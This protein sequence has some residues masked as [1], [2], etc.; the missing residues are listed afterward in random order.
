MT[1][2]RSPIHRALLFTTLIAGL[3]FALT[4]VIQR[5]QAETPKET[6]RA[7][8]LAV[9]KDLAK[10]TNVSVQGAKEKP[11]FIASPVFRYDDQP[12]RFIDATLW[13]WTVGG[14]PIAFEKI[15]A[16]FLDETDMPR[17]GFC[18]ASV[19][20]DLITAQWPGV[21]QFDS[22]EPAVKFQ[23]IP[24]APPVSDRET[25][26]KRQARELMRTF[27]LRIQSRPDSLETDEMRLLT[28]PIYEYSEPKSGKFLGAVYAFSTNGTNPDV[29]ILLEPK[30]RDDKL[31]WQFAPVRMTSGALTMKYKDQQ[32]WEQPYAFNAQVPF[33]TWTYFQL[34]RIP[35]NP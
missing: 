26:R 11:E 15:E 25:S 10:N 18:F 1:M 4:T 24:N 7:A 20:Q 29:L 13:V 22:K 33:P 23:V 9:M 32:I 14:R 35:L 12:R 5:C 34:P 3:G 31:E 16:M 30:T 27:S 28:T 17:W 8:M 21:P 2:F 6:P 19:T